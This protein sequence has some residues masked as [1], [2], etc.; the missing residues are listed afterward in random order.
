M[1]MR[2][3]KIVVFGALAAIAV[4][5]APVSAKKTQTPATESLKS[6]APKTDDKTDAQDNATPCHA[7]QQASDGSWTELPCQEPGVTAQ[8]QRKPAASSAEAR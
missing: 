8:A 5:T 6:Q 1:M 7:Y 3:G 4:T 2:I